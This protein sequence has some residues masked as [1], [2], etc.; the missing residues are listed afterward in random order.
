MTSGTKP[1]SNT[2]VL[3]WPLLSSLSS[4]PTLRCPCVSS[5]LDLTCP[6]IHNQ[7]SRDSQ[8]IHLSAATLPVPLVVT[9]PTTLVE[10]VK[11]KPT[12]TL[13]PQVR[14]TDRRERDQQFRSRSSGGQEPTLRIAPLRPYLWS[15]LD[16][17][18]PLSMAHS[19]L[20]LLRET[21]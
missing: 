10:L 7:S 15:R 14:V 12:P 1:D 5:I 18:D 20:C 2:D 19:P 21:V 4:S 11:A 9:P 6:I 3:I 8:I 13:I 17:R 16:P